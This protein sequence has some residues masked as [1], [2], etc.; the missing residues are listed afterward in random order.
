MKDIRTALKSVPRTL[1]ETYRNILAGI[2]QEDR[3]I[4]REMLLWVTCTAGGPLSLEELAEAAVYGS[5]HWIEDSPRMTAMDPDTRLLN[6]LDFVKT[7]RSLLR[8][9]ATSGYLGLAHASVYDYLTSDAILETDAAFFHLDTEACLF[10][11]TCCCLTYLSQPVFSDGYCGTEEELENR[12]QEWPLSYYAATYWSYFVSKQL[13]YS[14]IRSSTGADPGIDAQRRQVLDVLMRFMSSY[15][16]ARGGNFSSWFQV[17]YQVFEEEV[18]LNTHP[19]YCAAREGLIPVIKAILRSSGGK[20]WLD[21]PGGSCLSSPVHVAA[22]NGQTE[23]V[24]I[25]LDA[26]AD[27]NE[28]NRLGE[29]GIQWA[30]QHGFDD[31]VELFLAKGAN[32]RRI[33]KYPDLFE[34]T[35]A[36]R[37]FEV[38][39]D[40]RKW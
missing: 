29:S 18:L 6:P 7:C 32:P 36:E 17:V 10:K 16:L 5:M 33:Q 19:L 8:H 4:I 23:A 39:Q 31:I 9:D 34:L 2:S 37:Q 28:L 21:K 26:G 3:D 11:I 25:L 13:K 24:Q 15:T 27:P 40:V 20:A 1:E 22:A 38:L 30:H 14:E 35:L 12:L